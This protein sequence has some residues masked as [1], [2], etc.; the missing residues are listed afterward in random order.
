M[1]CVRNAL[2][3]AAGTV[4]IAAFAVVILPPVALVLSLCCYKGDVLAH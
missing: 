2:K 3:L 1:P 4:A